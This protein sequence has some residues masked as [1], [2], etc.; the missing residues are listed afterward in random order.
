[1]MNLDLG[2]PAQDEEETASNL[3]KA[4]ITDANLGGKIY[5]SFE[6]FLDKTSQVK[7]ERFTC[8]RN[9]SKHQYL[10]QFYG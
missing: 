3:L 6:N 4:K 10:K 7:Q 9:V 8:N 5:I 1:M 2:L